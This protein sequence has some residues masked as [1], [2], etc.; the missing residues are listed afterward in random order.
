MGST[1]CASTYMLR[2]GIGD[3]SDLRKKNVRFGS[4]VP[5]RIAAE[6]AMAVPS[7]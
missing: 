3:I 1:T 2:D 7:L 5:C 4:A 6:W